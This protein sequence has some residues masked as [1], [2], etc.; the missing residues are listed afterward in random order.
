MY[1]NK[2]DFGGNVA[3]KA[4]INQVFDYMFY[5]YEEFFFVGPK[6]GALPQTENISYPFD[7]PTWIF[8]YLTLLILTLLAMNIQFI[9]E[10]I[11]NSFIKLYWLKNNVLLHFVRDIVTWSPFCWYGECHLWRIIPHYLKG[12]LGRGFS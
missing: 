12:H 6:P 3:L 10:V 7:A 9:D 2:A 1:N 11:Y 8:L 4:D 5:A